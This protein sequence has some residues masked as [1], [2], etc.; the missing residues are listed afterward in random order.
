[1]DIKINIGKRLKELRLGKGLSQESF[2]KGTGVERTY[3]GDV[4][5]GKRN[6]SVETLSVLLKGLKISFKVL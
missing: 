2:S 4:E 1:M 5:N 3:I 6:I